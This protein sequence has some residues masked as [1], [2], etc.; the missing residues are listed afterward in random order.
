MSSC[1]LKPKNHDSDVLTEMGLEYLYSKD[2]LKIW[3]VDC[4]EYIVRPDIIIHNTI[5]FSVLLFELTCPLHSAHHLEQ[6]RYRKQNKVEYHQI[7]SESDRLNVTNFYETLEISVLGH[8]H[9]FSVTN[10]YN[11]YILLIRISISQSFQ[12][13][14][15]WTV[16]PEFV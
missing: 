5:T 2:I 16:P 9:Q 15:C 8:Y 13:E 10:T 12:F 6:A 3:Y 7:L 4:V 11:V 14:I 1:P